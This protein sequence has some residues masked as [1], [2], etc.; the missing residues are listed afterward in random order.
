M[1]FRAVPFEYIEKRYAFKKKK[2]KG[3]KEEEYVTADM[4]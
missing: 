3:A 1:Q 4:I 2:K